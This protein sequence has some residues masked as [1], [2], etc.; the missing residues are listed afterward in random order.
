MYKIFLIVFLFLN[1]SFECYASAAAGAGPSSVNAESDSK[2][3]KENEGE[4]WDFLASDAL[5]PEVIKDKDDLIIRVLALKNAIEVHEAIQSDQKKTLLSIFSLENMVDAAQRVMDFYYQH[6]WTLNDFLK[7]NME[8]ARFVGSHKSTMDLLR[9]FGTVTYYVDKDHQDFHGFMKIHFTKVQSQQCSAEQKKIMPIIDLL[10]AGQIQ[11]L[12][13]ILAQDTTLCLRVA[14]H[15]DM[16]PIAIAIL[17]E[18]QKIIA[19]LRLYK[20]SLNSKMKNGFI[21]LLMARTPQM[22]QYLLKNGA[23]IDFIDGNGETPLMTAVGKANSFI[24][25]DLLSNGAQVHTKG[26]GGITV[27]HLAFLYP[28]LMNFQEQGMFVVQESTLARHRILEMLFQKKK[29]NLCMSD[30][31]GVT[32]FMNAIEKGHFNWVIFF[33]NNKYLSVED[34]NRPDSKGRVPLSIAHEAVSYYCEHEHEECEHHKMVAILKASGAHANGLPKQKPPLMI[35]VEQGDE[36]AVIHLLKAGANFS[37]VYEGKRAEDRALK[38]YT[39]TGGENYRRILEQLKALAILNLQRQMKKNDDTKLR[40]E[41]K[42]QDVMEYLLKAVAEE[43][44]EIKEREKEALRIKREQKK[45]EERKAKELK[46]KEEAELEKKRLLA[47]EA[48]KQEEAEKARAAKELAAQEK[49]KKEADKKKRKKEGKAAR[50]LENAAEVQAIKAKA[51]ERELQEQLKQKAAQKAEQLKYDKEIDQISKWLVSNA[52]NYALVEVDLDHKVMQFQKN[53]EMKNKLEALAALTTL[54]L[55]QKKNKDMKKK[56]DQFRRM[57]VQIDVVYDLQEHAEKQKE[58]HAQK[59]KAIAFYNFN[60]KKRALKTLKAASEK[61]MEKTAAQFTK[62]H[63]GVQKPDHYT[64]PLSDALESDADGKEWMESHLNMLISQFSYQFLFNKSSFPYSR[65][66]PLI[67][68]Q[69]C[70]KTLDKEIMIRRLDGLHWSDVSK[71]AFMQN[72]MPMVRCALLPS[73][74]KM[75]ADQKGSKLNAHAAAFLLNQTAHSC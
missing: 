47:Q 17:H 73:I 53:K 43:E 50:K 22:K 60:V 11:K 24:A 48:L 28:P 62:H 54:V 42:K 2:S 7:K 27:L 68:C 9:F 8:H 19:L 13:S 66:V 56:A 20:A 10:R 29:V 34:L 5:A 71:P 1:F 45:E 49:A 58:K 26:L 36:E 55:R 67:S 69:S 61:A 37:A 39:E 14:N 16:H 64:N 70:A 32:P 51:L 21:P 46:E 75:L 30:D 44:R 6:G 3:S 23:D 57:N 33:L 4:S 31:N 52:V 41:K 15:F 25:Q 65:I 35:A 38:K 74:K 59:E 63:E 18:N 40:A 12:K 72:T